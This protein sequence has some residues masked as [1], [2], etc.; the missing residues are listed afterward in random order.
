MPALDTEELP[1][2]GSSVSRYSSDL[3][4]TIA[5]HWDIM[6]ELHEFCCQNPY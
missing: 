6:N 1:Y 4:Q 5:A 2:G 3:G